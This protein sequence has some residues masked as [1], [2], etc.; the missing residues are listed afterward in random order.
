MHT[1]QGILGLLLLFA[2]LWAII[3]VVT[4]SKRMLSKVCWTLIIICLPALGFLLWLIIGPR[5]R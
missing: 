4:S 1:Y 3:S 2:D 5:G